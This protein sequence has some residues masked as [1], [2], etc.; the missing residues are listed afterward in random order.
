M[1]CDCATLPD[2][3]KLETHPE[4]EKRTVEVATGSWVRLHRCKECSQ[5]WRIDE[6]D[7]Y[8]IQFVVRVPPGTSWQELDAD[9]L[10][11]QF[12]LQSRGGATNSE[13][14]WAG[15]HGSAVRGVAYCIDHLYETG[16]RE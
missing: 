7:K 3:F 1:V 11:K 8:Q 2:I 5:L 12:L 15:C 6:W 10:Q 13:C 16:A 14:A 9:P 4:L